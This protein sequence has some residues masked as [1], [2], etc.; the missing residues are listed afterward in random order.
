[1]WRKWNAPELL[2][3]VR[4]REGLAVLE[5]E[6][7]AERAGVG[8]AVGRDIRH[9]GQHARFQLIFALGIAVL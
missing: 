2:V 8:G 1:M 3:G 9:G 7:V 4:A 6:V 5:E